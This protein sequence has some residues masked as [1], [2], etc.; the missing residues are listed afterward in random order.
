MMSKS[1]KTGNITMN[2][3]SGS[4]KPGASKDRP[5]NTDSVQSANPL[6]SPASGQNKAVN[7][8][9]ML[10]IERGKKEDNQP[11]SVPALDAQAIINIIENHFDSHAGYSRFEKRVLRINQEYAHNKARKAY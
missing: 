3:A 5:Q 2:F 7:V 8:N 6:A 9:T 10:K 4:Q 11:V 1:E